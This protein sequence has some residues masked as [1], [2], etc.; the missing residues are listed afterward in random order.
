[1]PFDLSEMDGPLAE[2]RLVVEEDPE[3][4]FRDWV[5]SASTG[6]LK[7][8][9]PELENRSEADKALLVIHRLAQIEDSGVEFKAKL[10]DH[11][12]KLARTELAAEACFALGTALELQHR[13][14]EARDAYQRVLRIAPGHEGALG[15][16]DLLG[17]ITDEPLVEEAV[18]TRRMPYLPDHVS[19]ESPGMIDS[20]G[21]TAAPNGYGGRNGHGG[22]NAH[23]RGNGDADDAGARPYSGVSGGAEASAD[24]EQL[25]SE[26]RAE[27]H[28]KP[29]AGD[30]ASRTELGASLKG[31][32][33]LDDAIR[34]LQAAVNE[35]SP[36][37]MA[38]ELLGEAFLEKGQGRI[39]VRLLEKAVGTLGN[40]DRELMGVLYQLGVAYESLTDSNKALICYERIFSVDIDYRDIQERILA[41]SV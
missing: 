10:V 15:A 40:T 37:A 28:Q 34:E 3:D 31:M 22:I 33:R 14:A 18:E 6:V 39:A 25:L 13:Q 41:C 1:V 16:L 19:T 7:R 36:P 5:L 11:L 26:F 29:G 32:G 2:P 21:S 35:P 17:D 24:F 12:E 8:A 20:P 27:L 38:F 30:S 23:G 9:L 4:A